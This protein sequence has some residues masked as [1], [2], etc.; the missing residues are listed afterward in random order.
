MD[1]RGM[2]LYDLGED[3][4]TSECAALY[5]DYE[6]LAKR[7]VDQVKVASGG[8][9][10][11][12]RTLDNKSSREVALAKLNDSLGEEFYSQFISEA[13]LTAS[14]QHPNIIKVHDI[15]FGDDQK[16]YFT[17]EL[18]P[19]DSLREILKELANGSAQYSSKYSLKELIVIFLKVCDAVSYSHSLDILHL[20]IKPDNIQ[21]GDFGEVLLCDWG[22]SRFIGEEDHTTTLLSQDFLVDQTLNSEIKGTP[23]YM[24]P[25]QINKDFE[26]GFATDIYALG[27]LLYAILTQKCA[28]EGDV[29]S[30]L[31]QT[32]NGAI[33]PPHE[34]ARGLNI[35]AG[36]SA[37][38]MKAMSRQP[39]DRYGSVK[40]LA[41]DVS[42]HIEGYSTS[43]ENAGLLK[44]FN[45]FYKRNKTVVSLCIAFMFIVIIGTSIFIKNLNQSMNRE[46][47]LRKQAEIAEEDARDHLEMYQK[48]KELADLSLS[49][50]AEGVV[51]ELEHKLKKYIHIDTKRHVD[52]IYNSLLR[53]TEANKSDQQLYQ[54]KS[55][56]H[57]LRQ[58]F[59]LCHIELKKGMGI[60]SHPNYTYMDI[61]M[62]AVK[63]HP[64]EGEASSVETVVEMITSL[65][66]HMNKA[67]GRFLLYDAEVRHNNLEHF[68][69]A[70]ALILGHN[71]VTENYEV[72]YDEDNQSLFLKGDFR[73]YNIRL[74][75]P[76]V[77][78]AT[79]RNVNLKHLKILS[80]KN[81]IGSYL[82][83][84]ELE[85]LD[86]RG[87]S[88]VFEGQKIPKSVTHKI[89]LTEKLVHKKLRSYFEENFEVLWE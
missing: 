19:G 70:K 80:S 35:P 20:D 60:S 78:I 81:I 43:A 36:L 15:G 6:C 54:F 51:K 5:K 11:I 61:A 45:L 50:S 31:K 79:F 66:G 40:D 69:I 53:I 83:G 46:M 2:D 24:A 27:A 86:L 12:W 41:L 4:R 44:E 68:K 52:S 63:G 62:E 28:F 57:F 59:D 71:D 14:L 39:S 23:G 42:K 16:P 10:T 37:V 33:V 38:V 88:F 17:M 55:I 49:H 56:L 58:E 84:Y 13:R 3:I 22:L 73:F 87:M 25:E 77:S 48:E 72:T 74:S 29:E 89:Y 32:I 9:K 67:M 21:V 47:S 8:M 64:K 82:K 1:Y 7:Y 76:D 30:I 34:R 75:I 26:R 65:D 18:K 85:S